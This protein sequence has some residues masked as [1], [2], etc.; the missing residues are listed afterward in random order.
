MKEGLIALVR[1]YVV[2]DGCGYHLVFFEMKLA[3]WLFLQ[4]VVAKAEPAPCVIK[5]VPRRIGGHIESQKK[6]A[7]VRLMEC[8]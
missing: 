6:A 2:D 1:S 3:Q 7:H 4:L 8:I 5:T